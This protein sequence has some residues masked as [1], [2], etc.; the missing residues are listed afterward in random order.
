[1]ANKKVELVLAAKNKTGKA[2][3]AV[4]KNISTLERQARRVQSLG[5]VFTGLI[6][7]F[8]VISTFRAIIEKTK[9]QEAAIAQV[10]ARLKSTGGASQKTSEELQEMASSLQKVTTFGDEAILSMQSMLLTFTNIKGDNFDE[11]TKSILD[12]SV[13]LKI[14]LKSASI[15][16][17]KALNDPIKGVTA[18]TKSGVQ[19]TETQKDLIKSLVETGQTAKAQ[20]VI[21]DELKVQFGGAA[22]SAADTFGGALEQL[23]TAFGDLL[24]AK[25]SGLTRAKEEIQGLAAVLQDPKTVEAMN[26]LT[27]AAI[28][29]AGSMAGGLAKAAVAFNDV[30][31]AIGESL[32]KAVLTVQGASDE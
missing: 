26:N 7:G 29:M 1:M 14:D 17:G 8:G 21:L 25:G 13:A 6:A 32:A 31:I 20:G 28:S 2:F 3:D 30:G 4:N 19:F 18:L 15:Q 27:D 23:S 12:M 9:E 22:E 5:S 11:A 24:E 10:E 16:V